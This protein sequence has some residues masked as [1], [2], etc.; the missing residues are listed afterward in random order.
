MEAMYGGLVAAALLVSA[1]VSFGTAA[2][3]YGRGAWGTS[4]VRN[5]GHRRPIRQAVRR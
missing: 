5:R 3:R 1:V 2:S 4:T